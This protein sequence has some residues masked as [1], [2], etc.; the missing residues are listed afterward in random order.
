MSNQIGTH[1]NKSINDH[2]YQKCYLI[3]SLI[4]IITIKKSVKELFINSGSK[5]MAS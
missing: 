2:Y 5:S 1:D 3:N 4:N